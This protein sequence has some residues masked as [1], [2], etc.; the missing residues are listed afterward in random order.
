[1]KRTLAFF[2]L[3]AI[4][5]SLPAQIDYREGYLITNIGDSIAGF[6]NYAS[7]LSNSD[8]IVFK[9]SH[10]EKKRNYTPQEITAYGFSDL[11]RYETK[12]FPSSTTV[13]TKHF[14]EVLV[15]GKLSLHRF[16][17]FFYIETTELIRLPKKFNTTV[18]NELGQKFNKVVYPHISILNALLTDCGLNANNSMYTES[19]LVKLIA[20]YNRCK[21]KT[22]IVY[23]EKKEWSK[24][25][26]SIFSGIEASPLKL[27]QAPKS[28]TMDYAVISGIGLDIC[29]P[30]INEK[31][32]FTLNALFSDKVYQ[33][34]SENREN[35]IAITHIDRLIKV[36]AL[37][38][39]IGVRYNFLKE[40]ETPYIKFGV[41]ET[42]PINCSYENIKE[43]EIANVITTSV[44]KAD[45]NALPNT[46]L[47]F[48][49]G[50]NKTLMNRTKIFIEGRYEANFQYLNAG[51]LE[52][53][54]INPESKN[55]NVLIGLRF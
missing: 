34:Y 47:W 18:T 40:K 24:L 38:V 5:F 33:F 17:R 1:M 44:A 52:H 30:R 49:I 29:A 11:A 27:S 43:S 9:K 51:V 46:G 36:F 20:Q 31:I 14:V 53:E 45:V 2:I 16:K 32:M 54:G 42:F 4:P 15:K 50:Y 25:Y 55:I 23:K 39:P 12:E 7:Q 8:V 6:I 26:F 41:V 28:S 35:T 13:P 37:K 19:D 21:N 48:S 3:I 22:A 10:K